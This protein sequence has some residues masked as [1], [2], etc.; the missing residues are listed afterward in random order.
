MAL[1]SL[2]GILLVYGL[3]N[4]IMHPVPRGITL[5]GG[6]S[7]LDE[8]G[9]IVNYYNPIYS[10]AAAY[11]IVASMAGILMLVLHLMSRKRE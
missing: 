6:S 4:A 7:F 1:F 11:G 9:R 10:Q 8:N 2:A 5:Y 3:P